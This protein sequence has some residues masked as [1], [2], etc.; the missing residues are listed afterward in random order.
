[1]G[2]YNGYL[3]TDDY[4]VLELRKKI[5]LLLSRREYEDARIEVE[6]MKLLLDISNPINHQFLEA[7]KAYLDYKLGVI[8]E[9]E[10]RIDTR[11]KNLQTE[12]AAITKMMDSIKSILKENTEKSMN[13]FTSA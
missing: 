13:I 9:K 1:M 11:M 2:R 7:K 6:K 3:A 5:N 8:N 4:N 10:S 12:Q